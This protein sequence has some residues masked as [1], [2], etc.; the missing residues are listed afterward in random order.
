MVCADVNEIDKGQW[1]PCVSRPWVSALVAL[2]TCRNVNGVGWHGYA[3]CVVVGVDKVG[4]AGPE[5]GVGVLLAGQV[6]GRVEAH[7]KHG[8]GAVDGDAAGWHGL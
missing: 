6:D 8:V 4:G 7:Y 1:V 3:Q 2:E 5:R